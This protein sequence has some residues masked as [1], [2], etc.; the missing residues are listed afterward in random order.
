[1]SFMFILYLQNWKEYYI[2]Y[3]LYVL[4]VFLVMELK[5]IGIIYVYIFLVEWIIVLVYI[6]FFD[7]FLE[8]F[9]YL[10]IFKKFIYY[11]GLFVMGLMVIQFIMIW[12]KEYFGLMD[13]LNLV[14]YWVDQGFF[15]VIFVV[16]VYIL[17]EIYRLKNMLFRYI[18]VGI[19]ILLVSLILNWV[20]YDYFNVLLII[21]GIFFELFL[22]V[23]VIGYKINLLELEK[24]KIYE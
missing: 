1:M 19:C 12:I 6:L 23:V 8:I 5:F 9:S 18:L 24:W 21:F 20:F 11:L 2:I 14:V 10:K 17:Y 15:Y 7:F 22:F 4:G 13:I 3:I 16:G